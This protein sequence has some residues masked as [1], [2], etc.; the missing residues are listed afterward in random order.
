MRV[1]EPKAQ[2]AKYPH[3][4]LV[5]NE[6]RSLAFWLLE[7]GYDVYLGNIR[8]NFKM[9][10]RHVQHFFFLLFFFPALPDPARH[11]LSFAVVP[12][13]RSTLLGLGRQGHRHV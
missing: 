6:E 5:V 1:V 10:H 7:Q 3:A 12:P 8:T 2:L 13:K 11:I 9:P 4:R